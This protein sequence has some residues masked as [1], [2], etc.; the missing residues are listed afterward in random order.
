MAPQTSTE[1]PLIAATAVARPLSPRLKA[2]VL[3]AQASMVF[4]RS[5]LSNLLGLPFGLLICW[6]LWDKVDQ[7][8]LLGWL[9]AKVL[10]CIWRVVI[11]VA[12]RRAGPA[13][14]GRWLGH[15][16]TA[17]EWSRGPAQ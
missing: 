7:G 12:Q 5:R 14:A 1:P 4:E 3:A 17:H 16:Q 13:E 11:D 6:V 9:A 15:Y 10:V 8:L 2:K